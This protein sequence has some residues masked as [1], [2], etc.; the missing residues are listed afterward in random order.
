[1][2]QER[3]EDQLNCV[4]VSA[5]CTTGWTDW[6]HG[7]LWCCP[8][9]LLRRSLGLRA[10]IR[11]GV[12]PT[13]QANNPLVQSFSSGEI[14]SI[15][16]RSKRNRWI[17]WIAISRAELGLHRLDLDLVG[18]RRRTFMWPPVDDVRPL[19]NCLGLHIRDRLVVR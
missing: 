16:D 6:F 2:R 14:L 12:S 1:M 18:G 15:V 17:P 5:G 11:H 8:D 4:L 10:T 13:V 3:P 9:G 7:E 19:I